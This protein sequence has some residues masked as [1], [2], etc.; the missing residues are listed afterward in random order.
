MPIVALVVAIAVVAGLL[1]NE[2]S[3]GAAPPI[4]KARLVQAYPH[5]A[6][7]FCQGLVIHEGRLV[8]GTGQYSHS[9]LRLVDIDSGRSIIDQKLGSEVFGEGVTIWKDTILQLTWR[10]GYLIKYDAE[11]LQRVGTVRYSQIDPT[12]REGWGIA[13]DGHSLIISDGSSSLRFVNPETFRLERSLNVRSGSKALSKLN[14]LEFVNG[15]I[16]ANVWYEDRIACIDAES[17]VVTEWIELSH[18][19]PRE[20]K[21]NREAVLNGI[22]WDE[23]SGRLFITGKHWPNLFEISI[24]HEER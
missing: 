15:Q 17:G 22:A 23:K 21:G 3:A 2:S 7:A 12:L 24:D 8:E 18:L 13:H 20:V 10:N 11:T 14:E 4:T 16:L 19:R 6:T 1:I 5:D 9:R